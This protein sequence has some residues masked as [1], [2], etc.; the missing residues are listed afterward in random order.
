MKEI[1]HLGVYFDHGLRWT[2]QTEAV[3][4]KTSKLKNLFKILTNSKHGPNIDSLV[5][6][7]KAL[8]RGRI[9]YGIMF[10]GTSSRNRQK[11]IEAIQNGIMRIILGAPQSTPIKEMLLELDLQPITK[12]KS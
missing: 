4:Q 7:Y 1:K 8:V 11:K 5:S 9:D 2:R 12:R 6:M 10:A 3:I